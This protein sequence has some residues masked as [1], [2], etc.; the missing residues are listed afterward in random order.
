MI[1][2]LDPKIN[3]ME[4]V[5]KEL[6]GKYASGGT[7]KEGYIFAKMMANNN[8]SLINAV[9]KNN[10]NFWINEEIHEGSDSKFDKSICLPITPVE[11]GKTSSALISPLIFASRII[12]SFSILSKGK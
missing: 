4:S 2:G 1:E 11:N 12:L 7:A 3:N 10:P 8:E 6:K 9:I 5:A